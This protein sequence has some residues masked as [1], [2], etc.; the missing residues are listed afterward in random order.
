M[1][2]DIKA[3]FDSNLIA[4][5][6]GSVQVFHFDMTTREFI[7]AEEIYIHVGVG[8]PAFSCLEEPPV[9]SEY[10]VAVRSD[11][12][13]SWSVTDDY[14]GITVY[15]IQTLASHVITEPGPIPDTVTTF[16]PSTPYDKWDGSAWIIDV[17]AQHAAEVAVADVQKKEL[18]AQASAGISILQDAMTLGM[19]TDEEKSRL[20]SLQAY[21]VRLNRVDTSLAPNI[22]WPIEN[23][24]GVDNG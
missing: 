5:Q 4:T 13:S 22:I 11:D 6:A 17:D 8:L 12:N 14:R 3:V 7:G 23:L 19:A 1:S 16:A 21:R 24:S 10:Q 9:Q 18:I 15:D 2:G 20:T